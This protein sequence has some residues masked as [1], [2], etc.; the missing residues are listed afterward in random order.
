MRLILLTQLAGECY[1]SL[2]ATPERLA[3][4]SIASHLAFH[5]VEIDADAKARRAYYN[6]GR[7]ERA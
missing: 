1:A 6:A 2:T 5:D 7:C 4:S 3:D